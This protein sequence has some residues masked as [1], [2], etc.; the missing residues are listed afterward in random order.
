MSTT[1]TNPMNHATT[2]T[3]VSPTMNPN[4]SPTMTPNPSPNMNPNAPI[5]PAQATAQLDAI[6]SGL[7]LDIVVP[8]NDKA[9]IGALK[10]VT[11][12]AI[13]LAAQIVESDPA[14]FPDFA[15]LP[16]EAEHL[17]AMGPLVARSA[18]FAAHV[19]KDLSNRRTP[20][21]QKT[22]ALYAVVKSLGRIVDNETM[23]EKVAE[24]KTELAP[25]RKNPK[26]KQ[27]KEERQAKRAA[28]AQTKRVAKAMKV[29]AEA[30]A[31]IAPAPPA[32]PAPPAPV[33]TNG[34]APPTNATH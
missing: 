25:K 22:L 12:A 17:A 2:P 30:G 15:D 31:P 10:R 5:T 6:E 19:E 11:D 20:A 1:E 9:Q 23:R 33:A 24:L 34:A 18:S 13:A 16:A 21:A 14:R 32:S 7:A 26:P 28:K 3:T 8:P 27:T 4:P 29:L